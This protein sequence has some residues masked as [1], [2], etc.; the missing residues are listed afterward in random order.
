ML[1]PVDLVSLLEGRHTVRNEKA[2]DPQGNLLKC[3]VVPAATLT[4]VLMAEYGD[5]GLGV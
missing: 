2:Y 4:P 1:A 3:S 5:R